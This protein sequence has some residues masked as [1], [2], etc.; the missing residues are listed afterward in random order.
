M[1]LDL[2]TAEPEELEADVAIVGAGAAGCTIART[3]LDRGY[4]V[5]L[6]E[7]GGLDFEA[8]TADLNRGE[9]VGQPYYELDQARLRFFGG[10]TA[11]WGGRCAELDAIDF[12]KRPWVPHSGWPIT[13]DELRPWYSA[14]W[15]I[16]GIANEDPNAGDRL[17]SGLSRH[18]LV[19]R[20]WWFDGAFDRF[21][22]ARN[23]QLIDHERSLVAIHATVREVVPTEDQT[24][25]RHLR[26]WSPGGRIVTAR[27]RAYVLA[28]GGLENPR[29]LLASDSVVPAGVGNGH[30]LVG[31]FFMEHPHAR[32]G[33]IVRGPVWGLLSAFARKGLNGNRWSPLLTMTDAVQ[34]R[35]GALNSGLTIAARPPASGRQAFAKLAYDFVKHKTPPTDRG[36]MLWRAWRRLNRGAG[37]LGQARA[38]ART[39]VAGDELALVIRAEQ[40]PNPDSRVRLTSDTD[41]SGMQRIALDWRLGSQDSDSVRTLVSVFAGAAQRAGLGTVQT[42]DWLLDPRSG[43]AI[44][45]LVSAHPLGGYHHLGTTRMADDPRSGVT[46]RWGRVHGLANLYVA[47]SSLFPTGG[48]ANP[49]LT[50]VAL[51]LRTADHLAAIGILDEA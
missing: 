47:G 2:R 45:P 4:R 18:G 44:D 32:G 38:F 22:A 42:A 7:S 13:L 17:L 35:E 26:V 40:A 24:S 5:L 50:I 30:D 48:W 28:A 21:G 49:T 8:D 15:Q 9:I 39:I 19:I 33:R 29:I 27:A 37:K 11:M 34:Q 43:W 3:L 36:R 51:A 12:E 46:D 6:L 10:T 23:R 14:A 25:I 31:R 41:A 20:H 16:F 1:L